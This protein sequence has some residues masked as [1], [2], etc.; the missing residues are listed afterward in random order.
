MG[1]EIRSVTVSLTCNVLS[2]SSE[3]LVPMTVILVFYTLVIAYPVISIGIPKYRISV[4]VS[5]HMVHVPYVTRSVLS[6][7]SRHPH[8][9]WATLKVKLST[10]L[11][12]RPWN[13]LRLRLFTTVS[14]EVLKPVV[15]NGPASHDGN[16]LLVV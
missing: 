9:Q 15:R 6:E 4:T 5:C 16:S 10:R 13:V 8:K 12:N 7:D 11:V 2:R 3:T 14:D 1:T